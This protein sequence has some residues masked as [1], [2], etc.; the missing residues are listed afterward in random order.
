MSAIRARPP[1]RIRCSRTGAHRGQALVEFSL[2]VVFL[3]FLLIGVT[4]IATLLDD[5]EVVVYA[6]RQ[7]ARTGAVIGPQANADCAIVGAV[8]SAMGNVNNLTLTQIIIYN[9]NNADGSMYNNEEDVYPG[10]VD[11]I[12]GAIK[13]PANQV[14]T[15]SP[16][17]WPP[18]Q[19]NGSV[20]RNNTPFNTDSIGVELIYTYQW[21][22]NVFG[23][24]TF[25][26]SD[27]AVFPI[28]PDTIPTPV[29]TATS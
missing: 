14:V 7:G 9:A 15:P 18:L 26:A 28:N 22:F 21:Q 12:G 23:T 13:N 6:A 24:P 1:R 20:N 16:G 27:A 3:L 11:C 2:F 19:A 5:H 25:T 10:N 8:R 4:D 29:P 17:T